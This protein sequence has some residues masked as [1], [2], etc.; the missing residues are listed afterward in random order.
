MG[1]PNTAC[2]Q[3]P[4]SRRKH[5]AVGRGENRDSQAIKATEEDKSREEEKGGWN[6]RES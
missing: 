1:G 4:V 6:G 3:S 2:H 5:I